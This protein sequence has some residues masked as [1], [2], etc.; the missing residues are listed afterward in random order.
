MSW[1]FKRKM[2]KRLQKVGASVDESYL[3]YVNNDDPIAFPSR[4]NCISYLAEYREHNVI[5]RIQI[6]RIETYSL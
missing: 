3:L 4:E 5:S 2:S 6:Y 1:L